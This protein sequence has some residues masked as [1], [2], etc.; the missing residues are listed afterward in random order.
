LRS[1]QE[2]YPLILCLHFFV[3][4]WDDHLSGASLWSDS[5][6]HLLFT[7]MVPLRLVWLNMND[8]DITT[9]YD[10]EQINRDEKHSHSGNLN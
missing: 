5:D 8:T 10:I 2:V 9:L 7:K 3:F 4:K 6:C 1:L